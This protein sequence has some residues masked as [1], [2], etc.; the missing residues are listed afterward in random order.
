MILEFIASVF[1]DMGKFWLNLMPQIP[2]IPQTIADVGDYIIT[3]IN[4][5]SGVI[6]LIYPGEFLLSLIVVILVLINFDYI[7]YG[8]LWVVK[9]LPFVDIK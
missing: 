4:D 9:K 3:W 7:Y 2:A 6:Q 5:V 1:F 8:I